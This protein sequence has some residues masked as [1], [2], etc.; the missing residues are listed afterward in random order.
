MENGIIKNLFNSKLQ[1]AGNNEKKAGRLVAKKLE[2]LLNEEKIAPEDLRFD[3]LA[4][5][6]IPDYEDLRTASTEDIALAVSSSQFPTISKVAINKVVLD[7]YELHQEGLDVLVSELNATRTNEEYIAGFTDPEGP[8]LRQEAQS[9]QET[10]FGERDVT[11]KM[12]DFGRTIS[13]TREAIYN[14]RTG[15]LLSNARS[16]G[17]KGGQHRAQ[18]IIQTLECYPRTAFKEAT[19]AAN[20]FIYKGTAVQFANFYNATNHTAIDGRTNANLIASNALADYTDVQAAMDLFVDMTTPNGDP[21][22]VMPKYVIVH[23]KK[24]NQA[25][26]IFNSA[27]YL[28]DPSNAGTGIYHQPN[29]FGPGGPGGSFKVIGTRYL[30]AEGTWYIGD[31]PKQVK[32]L[33]VWRPSTASLAA[34]SEKAFY[35]NIVMTYKFSYHG[36]CGNSDYSYAVKS[37]A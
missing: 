20:A 34:S 7:S 23:E 12:A 17:E 9:Y 14:D 21:M 30:S 11:I 5:D 19:G 3:Q 22:A 29:P 26:Q 24:I 18:M 10:N 1:E 35:N 27:T 28:K 16:F 8:E 6:L 36:G 37:T 32:W 31:F 33:W 4:H 13:V 25:W 2:S 15:Q